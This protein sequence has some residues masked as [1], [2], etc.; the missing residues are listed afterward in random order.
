MWK[1]RWDNFAG[2]FQNFGCFAGKLDSFVQGS[3][4]GTGA[5]SCFGRL[6]NPDFFK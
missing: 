6:Q 5:F 3:G 2:I 1:F 4:A